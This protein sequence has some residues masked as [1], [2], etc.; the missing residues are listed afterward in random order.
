M[1]LKGLNA[2]TEIV[3][4][5]DQHIDEFLCLTFSFH[6]WARGL[7]CMSFPWRCVVQ[8]RLF[9]FVCIPA[10]LTL[11]G[12][13]ICA[14]LC[15]TPSRTSRIKQWWGLRVAML[16]H[17]V[18]QFGSH[19][20]D[21]SRTLI[22]SCSVFWHMGHGNIWLRLCVNMLDNFRWLVLSWGKKGWCTEILGMNV[23][24][25]KW[26][27]FCINLCKVEPNLCL[28]I[29]FFLPLFQLQA[30]P[31]LP[32]GLGD[33]VAL[34]PRCNAVT[35]LFLHFF[36]ISSQRLGF[37]MQFSVSI[38]QRSIFLLMFVRDSSFPFSLP[39]WLHSVCKALLS[40][41]YNCFYFLNTSTNALKY[42][43]KDS[44]SESR[45]RWT[46]LSVGVWKKTWLAQHSHAYICRY[47]NTRLQEDLI[48]YDHGSMLSLKACLKYITCMYTYTYIW[49]LL[50]N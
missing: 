32:C 29:F 33:F 12:S 20:E 36:C 1:R 14:V 38:D 3:I 47:L 49:S 23:P 5:F 6:L 7:F 28:L 35:I 19:S 16:S 11:L 21:F 4:S 46:L 42:W 50:K 34:V 18:R 48:I 22:G 8:T 17:Q 44:F 30:F 37:A 25:A 15:Q 9:T 2:K 41:P 40:F 24:V 27:P 26:A 10:S 13:L 43:W 45:H 31:L 39:T